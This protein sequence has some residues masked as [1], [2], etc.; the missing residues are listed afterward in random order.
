MGRRKL[1]PNFPRCARMSAPSTPEL[2]QM[3]YLESQREV[4]PPLEPAQQEAAQSP[5]PATTESNDPNECPLCGDELAS[6]TPTWTCP[7]TAC[8]A[9]IC[10]EC[11]DNHLQRDNRCPFCRAHLPDSRVSGPVYGAEQ[12]EELAL[13]EEEE[14][15]GD[16]V[17]AP[18]ELYI[19]PER[20]F[21]FIAEPSPRN[22]W[23]GT[24]NPL[25][26]QAPPPDLE[27]FGVD[28]EFLSTFGRTP[29]RNPLRRAVDQEWLSATFMATAPDALPAAFP[30][31]PFIGGE[32]L[33]PEPAPSMHG[34]TETAESAQRTRRRLYTRDGEPVRSMLHTLS[35]IGPLMPMPPPPRSMPSADEGA[36][37]R[38]PRRALFTRDGVPVRSMLAAGMRTTNERYHPYRRRADRW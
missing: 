30:P 27:H 35:D 33:Q 34:S 31:P 14:D 37:A 4:S 12:D 20:E 29:R 18:N 13:L 38:R 6:Y 21:S 17:V 15:D 26:T 1:P 25:H 16:I 23:E 28:R 7:N 3:G 32:E 2:R 9:A 10:L 22:F 36:S 11:R 8:H 24:L 5:A 19:D